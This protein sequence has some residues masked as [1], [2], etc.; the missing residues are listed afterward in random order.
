MFYLGPKR[1]FD[2][3]NLFKDKPMNKTPPEK[4]PQWFVDMAVQFNAGTLVCL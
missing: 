3:Y 2:L 1:V 4:V